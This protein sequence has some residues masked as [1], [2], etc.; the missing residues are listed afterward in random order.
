MTKKIRGYYLL[1]KDENITKSLELFDDGTYKLKKDSFDSNE[2]KIK[3]ID[4]VLENSIK[5]IK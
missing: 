4:E 5:K 2:E 3:Y 1:D